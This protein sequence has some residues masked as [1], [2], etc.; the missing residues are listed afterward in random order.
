MNN[1]AE[2]AENIVDSALDL[3]PEKRVAY[4][5]QA[6]AG[7]GALRRLAGGLL[8][9]HEQFDALHSAPAARA[10]TIV[11]SPQAGERPGDQI[12]SYKLLQQIGEGGYGVVYMA[13]QQQPVR[14][15]VAL[16]ILKLGM[17]TR[18]VVARFEQ[19]RQARAVVDHPHIAKVVDAG[20]T[21]SVRP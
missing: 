10:E 13:E 15:R 2:Q 6:C 16:K 14:R 7:D 21:V 1:L 9:A 4:L 8:R 17:D 20:T 12:G 5:D 3:A 19:E 11:V 18:E